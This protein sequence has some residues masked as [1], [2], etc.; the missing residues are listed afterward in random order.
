MRR[1]G[2]GALRSC[3]RWLSTVAEPLPTT[4]LSVGRD[5]VRACMLAILDQ[6]KQLLNSLEDPM[7]TFASPL[8]EASVGQ[9]TRHSLDHLRKPL[10]AFTD[11]NEDA[12][13]SLLI[14]Y[15]R[16]E[17]KT[18]VETDRHAAVELIEHL[19]AT[20]RC[21]GANILKWRNALGCAS[22]PHL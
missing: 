5:G 11:A 19:Q 13:A 15:D 2:R 20:I 3:G 17:R 9:H 4:A 6:Q 12:N 10:E 18:A 16:R 21:M 22:H 7:Y 14:C 8:F 1:A